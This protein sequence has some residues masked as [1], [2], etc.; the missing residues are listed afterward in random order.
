M[1]HISGQDLLIYIH[2]FSY[3]A[4]FII[5][6]GESMGIPLPGETM[7]LTASIYAGTTH[8]L[9]ILFVILAASLGAIIGDNLGYIIGRKGG[10]PLLR[11][12]GK[13]IKLDE[14][15]LKV[16]QYLYMRQG[17]KIVFFGRF[18]T[19]LR[20]WAAFLA[21][22][23]KMHWKSFLLFNAGGGIVWASFYGTLGFLLG[24]H[25]QYLSRPL[26]VVLFFV[27]TAFV[28]TSF[29]YMYNN[30]KRLE[31][32]AEQALPGPLT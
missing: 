11:H 25:V 23:N 31:K 5:I 3:I 17:G 19:V 21:G 1:F 26:R 30:I 7:L 24:R 14:A 2:Q 9:S 18:V 32:K 22:V 16:G 4:I 27:G 13:Y 29:L 20:T 10:Y 28:I 15:K 12:F 6:A 8:R